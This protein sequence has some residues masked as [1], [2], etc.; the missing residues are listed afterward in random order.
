LNKYY[1]AGLREMN[2]S[3][4]E[5]AERSRQIIN[6][7][8]EDKTNEKIKDLLPKQS[9]DEAIL[10]LTNA[11][12]FKGF[13]ETQFNPDSTR[14]TVFTTQPDL[15]TS[16]NS[17]KNHQC[18]VPMMFQKG[19]FQYYSDPNVQVLHLPYKSKQLSMIVLLPQK[20]KGL[21]QFTKTLILEKL[22]EWLLKG[23]VQEVEVFLPQFKMTWLD[24]SLEKTLEELGLPLG[25]DYSGISEGGGLGISKVVHKAFVEVNEEGTEAA[26]A[27]AV[28]VARSAAKKTIFRA[29]RPFMFLIRDNQT[30]TILFMGRLVDPSKN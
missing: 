8:V 25:G 22:N 27:T 1:G 23:Q 17:G 9:V 21:V 15:S 2:F 30:G 19:M 18:K 5:A 16:N 24:D 10:V 13:W 6:K 7:W 3:S 11:I 14:E 20:N 28:V 12:Y 26:A 29:D 4:P